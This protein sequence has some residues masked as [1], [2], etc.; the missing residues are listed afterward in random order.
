MHL[1]LATDKTIDESILGLCRFIAQ[2]GHV[3]ILRSDINGSNF[4][5]EEIELNDVLTCID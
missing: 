4:I 5:G 3:K 1:E 2:C